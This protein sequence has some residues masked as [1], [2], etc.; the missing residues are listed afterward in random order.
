MTRTVAPTKNLDFESGLRAQ[1][2]QDLRLWLRIMA[3]H[4]QIT[5]EVRRRLRAQF[6]MSLARFDFMAQLDRAPK[7][8]RMGEL[9]ARLMVTTGNITALT[10]ELEADG[11]VRRE[12]DPSHRRAFLLRL[13]PR[14]REIFHAAAQANERWLVEFFSILSPRDKKLVFEALGAL[15]TDVNRILKR[16]E[17]EQQSAAATI[18]R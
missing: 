18:S 6:D 10:D 2:H 16:A 4:K 12:A 1:E 11:F 8:M 15:K 9:S 17:A 5:N 7:G 13:T 3:V 14:G